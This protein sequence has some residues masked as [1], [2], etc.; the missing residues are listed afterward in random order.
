MVQQ[1]SLHCYSST[2][3]IRVY[4]RSIR[5]CVRWDLIKK[6]C[7]EIC[8]DIIAPLPKKKLTLER[9]ICVKPKPE[10]KVKNLHYTFKYISSQQLK[11]KNKYSLELTGTCRRRMVARSFLLQAQWFRIQQ[12][13]NWRMGK[14][15]A[16]LWM[17]K[18]RKHAD[19]TG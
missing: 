4:I 14:Y 2:R 11:F 6:N 5:V 1:L 16:I 15:F 8:A 10:C 12:I 19:W 18:R 17:E 3:S 9:F 7:L 13:S